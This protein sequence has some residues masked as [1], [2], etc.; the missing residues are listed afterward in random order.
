M[1]SKKSSKKAAAKATRGL[2]SLLGKGV[3]VRAVTHYYTGRLAAITPTELVLDD[4]AWIADTGRFATALG[5]GALNEIEPYP[6]RC[7][8]SRGAVVD[9]AEWPH[10]LPRETK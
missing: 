4:A 10:P 7:Y 9:V 6:G 3:F 1:K 5:T 8:V 2:D